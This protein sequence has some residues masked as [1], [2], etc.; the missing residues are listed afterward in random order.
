M[1]YLDTYKQGGPIEKVGFNWDLPNLDF[2]IVNNS[3]RT[4]FLTEVCFNIEYSRLDPFPLLVVM[5]DHRIPLKF[6]ISNDG[7][8]HVTNCQAKFHL[9]PFGR[10]NDTLELCDSYPHE[11]RIDDFLEDII[12]DISSAF[13]EEGLNLTALRSSKERFGSYIRLEDLGEEILEDLDPF[14]G[15]DFLENYGAI[16]TGELIYKYIDGRGKKREHKV[17][18]STYVY[19]FYSAPNGMMLPPTY[20]YA[21]KFD[22]DRANYLRSVE[23]SHVLKPGEADR[24]TIK[25]GTNKSSIHSFTVSLLHNAGQ[26]LE[27]QKIELTTFVPRLSAKSVED[28]PNLKPVTK[29]RKHA[30]HRTWLAFRGLL[31]RLLPVRFSD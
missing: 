12:V 15:N 8:G 30:L 14:R 24:F 7:W 29:L 23:I 1:P 31:N 6:R 11:V 17:K 25:I 13:E 28:E 9:T 18:F 3:N 21:T 5:S 20:Q 26:V 22:V 16:V 19:I 2:K 27:S 4:V 10:S